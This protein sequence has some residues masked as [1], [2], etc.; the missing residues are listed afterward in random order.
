MD[1][2]PHSKIFKSG[3]GPGEY[4]EIFAMGAND[5]V[6]VIFDNVSRKLLE[7]DFNGIFM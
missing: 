2:S 1:G 5:S 4:A 6:I 7:Y 3:R